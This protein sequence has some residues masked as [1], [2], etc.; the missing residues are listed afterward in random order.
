MALQIDGLLFGL[1]DVKYE[2]WLYTI[3]YPIYKQ[4]QEHIPPGRGTVIW[5]DDGYNEG[6]NEQ[7]ITLFDKDLIIT[8]IDFFKSDRGILT[9]GINIIVPFN[10]DLETDSSGLFQVHVDQIEIDYTTTIE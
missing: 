6:W 4:G 8:Y 3:S 2:K 7:Y 10:N 1:F 5:D 9:H